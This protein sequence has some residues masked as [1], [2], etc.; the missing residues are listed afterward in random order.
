MVEKAN[1]KSKEL[2]KKLEEIM[3]CE[4]CK[5]KYDYNLHR[6]LIVKCGH[7]FCKNCIY[8]Q[9]Q[10]NLN[11]N[12]N[13]KSK[14]IFTCPID[15]INH[16][17]TLEKNINIQ[18]PTTYQNLLLEIILKE[19]MNLNEPIIKE[20]YIVYSKPD[21]KRNKS[22]EINSKHT[23]NKNERNIQKEKKDNINIKINSGNQII[24]VNAIN[25]NIDTGE[26]NKNINYIEKMNKDNDS[27][28]N[29]D[30]N[31]L[32]I[33]EE[34]NI[35]ENK[36]NFEN[37]KINDDSIETIPFEEKSMTNMSFK[38]DFKE[39]LNKNDEFKYQMSNNLNLKT[40]K[41]ID[42][43]SHTGSKKKFINNIIKDSN[44]KNKQEMKMYNKRMLINEKNISNNKLINQEKESK[45]NNI[46][47]IQEK[48][49]RY[50]RNKK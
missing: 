44:S 24:N 33:N 43:F 30:L 21:L 17:F 41:N 14:N 19:I 13:L 25:V 50:K 15:N 7:T 40:E 5:S 3:K 2:F 47:Y 46:D 42:I 38:D 16:I 28:L 31:N 6:P 48:K 39:L 12:N 1:N 32:K 29:D 11:F 10:K 49:R 34:M 4:I 9:R 36:L 26:K 45:S 8:S 35:N 22:P 20:K 23:I 18:E 37:E 27:M